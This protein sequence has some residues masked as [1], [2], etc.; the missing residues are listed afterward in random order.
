MYVWSNERSSQ[1]SGVGGGHEIHLFT[2]THQE[3]TY[4][5]KIS[6][7]DLLSMNRGPQPHKSTRKIPCNQAGWRKE[8]RKKKWSGSNGHGT[9]GWGELKVRS[10]SYLW[11]SPLIGREMSWDKRR[12][13][14]LSE[15]CINWPV[16]GRTEWDLHRWSMHSPAF[17]QPEMCGHGCTWGLGAGMWVWTADPGRRLLLVVRWQPGD[18]SADLC[19]WEFLGRKSGSPQKKS[20]FIEW[21]TKD[22]ATIADSHL[23]IGQYLQGHQ[24]GLMMEWLVS[25]WSAS[26]LPPLPGWP[27][28]PSYHLGSLLCDGVAHTNSHPGTVPPRQPRHPDCCL[29]L[30]LPDILVC[31]S[32]LGSRCQW[33]THIQRRI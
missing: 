26:P 13:S 31:S 10:S 15:E 33:V 1:D 19:N 7:E 3:C 2:Q 28:C 4:K 18:G 6:T 22:R 16:A 27:T 12:A 23:I 11:E 25:P 8:E 21:H 24:T 17:P 5:W 20:A 29:H 9:P 32:S 30:L 14:G